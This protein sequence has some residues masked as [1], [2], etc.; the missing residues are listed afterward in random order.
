[1]PLSLASPAG[2]AVELAEGSFL[3][4]LHF[5]IGFAF[6]SQ[7]SYP[8]LHL[9]VCFWGVQQLAPLAQVAW[10]HVVSILLGSAHLLRT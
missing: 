10:K 2:K 6:S 8:N 7:I 3:S 4:L 1:M 5:H 9:R